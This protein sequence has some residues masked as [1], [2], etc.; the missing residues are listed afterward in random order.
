VGAQGWADSKTR[1]RGGSP[2]IPRNSVVRS[3]TTSAAH[4]TP[5]GLRGFASTGGSWTGRPFQIAQSKICGD[6]NA[7]RI[8]SANGLALRIG[9]RWL[10]ARHPLPAPFYSRKSGGEGVPGLAARYGGRGVGW[11]GP[12]AV[13]G[14]RCRGGGWRPRGAGGPPPRRR[15][16]RC[17]RRTGGTRRAQARRPLGR[18]PRR[19]GSRGSGDKERGNFSASNP[20]G[21]PWDKKSLQGRPECGKLAS[22]NFGQAGPLTASH[23]PPP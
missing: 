19:W 5:V 22:S 3:R 10:Q 16:G 17:C 15:G 8:S 23:A 2:S 21:Q 13:G 12:W 9:L 7:G 14:R 20:C 1:A 18:G 11:R 4:R 6:G